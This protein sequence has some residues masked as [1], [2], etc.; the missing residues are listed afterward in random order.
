MAIADGVAGRRE[1]HVSTD[2]KD[3]GKSQPAMPP[4]DAVDAE[5]LVQPG[6]PRHQHHLD[7]RRIRA[8]QGGELTSRRQHRA[9]VAQVGQL[10][11]T[12]PHGDDQRGIGEHNQRDVGRPES[13][14]TRN[15]ERAPDGSGGLPS[16]SRGGDRNGCSGA[17]G[18]PQGWRAVASN[19][20]LRTRKL[21]IA[22]VDARDERTPSRGASAP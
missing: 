10:P 2:Q 22:R 13:P 8:K 9:S 1:D 6:A 17:L 3:S 5:K 14:R 20:R 16:E 19:R 15:A 4:G 11:V 18:Y 12:H 7:D 21:L